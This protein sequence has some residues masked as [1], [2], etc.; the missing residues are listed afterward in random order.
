MGHMVAING[1][2][3]DMERIADVA[4]LGVIEVW[5]ITS[6][7]SMMHSMGHPFHIH[8]VQFQ[9]LSR[10]SGQLISN[11]LGWKDTVF[12]APGETVKIMVQFEEKGIFMYHCHILE[13]EEA[14]MM[15]QIRVE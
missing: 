10:S 5:E 1:R 13:H 14:G 2:K 12:V 9:I 15:G 7:A 8:G 4:E 3:C 6:A 11:E